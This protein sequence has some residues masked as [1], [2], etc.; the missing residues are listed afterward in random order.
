M[1]KPI[2]KSQLD[3]FEEIVD[4]VFSKLGIDVEFT[5]HFLDRINDDRNGEQITI[6][7]LGE[8]F[9]KE[10]RRWGRRISNMP[11]DSE[12]VMKDLSSE[13]NLPFVLKR[14]GQ[15]K[16]LVAKTIMRKKEFRTTNPELPVESNQKS[17]PLLGPSTAQ[18]RAASAEESDREYI[19]QM[20]LKS[21]WKA[22]FP[23][24]KWPGY[25]R[26]SADLNEEKHG[27]KRGAQVRGHDATTKKSRPT[28]GNETPH[29]MR[30]KLVGESK[31]AG[32]KSPVVD[33]ANG[34]PI[35]DFGKN[36][37][38]PEK[39]FAVR[40]PAIDVWQT[41]APTLADARERANNL[42]PAHQPVARTQ[43]QIDHEN[44]RDEQRARLA[45]GEVRRA[46]RSRRGIGEA[47]EPLD[48]SIK[49]SQDM[50]SQILKNMRQRGR[51]QTNALQAIQSS[52][53]N[54]LTKHGSTVDVALRTAQ[55]IAKRREDI[56]GDF[57]HAFEQS[58]RNKIERSALYKKDYFGEQAHNKN[59]YYVQPDGSWKR[60]GDGR[61]KGRT[62]KEIPAGA[63]IVETYSQDDISFVKKFIKEKRQDGWTVYASR[64]SHRTEHDFRI[65]FERD[66]QEFEVIGSGNYW[67][68][69][70]G[71]THSGQ[72]E[73]FD[74]LDTAFQTGTYQNESIDQAPLDVDTSSAAEI[75]QKHG[76]DLEMIVDQL[77]RGIK[78]EMEHTTDPFAALEIALDHLEEM[79][80]YYSKLDDMERE[81]INAGAWECD[82][83]R[84]RW[85]KLRPGLDPREKIL[86]K[87]LE[88]LDKL[89][90]SKGTEKHSIGNYAFDIV[91]SFNL[92]GIATSR[93]LTAMYKE[94]KGLEK[95][96]V[97]EGWMERNLYYIDEIIATNENFQDGKIKGK[98]RPGRA[99]RAGVDASKSVSDLRKQAKNSSGETQKMAHWAANMKSGRRK[100]K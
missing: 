67:E 66:G 27:A 47:Q 39:R 8:L 12:A 48:G 56:P 95:E 42:R 58:L 92:N 100:K 28:T 57:A 64:T 81:Q 24:K 20:M 5:R 19:E 70:R 26:A 87:A 94:W 69:F 45:T 71:P 88:Y 40:D 29:P 86:A 97:Y 74:G 32:G 18:D 79:P 1:S 77:Q 55:R 91:R 76:V 84:E 82:Q 44:W 7:E 17:R 72:G 4:R 2:T 23:G 59:L 46:V 34:Y 37:P 54:Q 30:G 16:D 89:V 43:A 98:S 13:L 9:A 35:H 52:M 38:W 14:D 60:G 11:V 93:E 83:L 85:Q 61:S 21:K 6:K 90:Q 78:V 53:E 33:T 25:S 65:E 96:S 15:E 80:D 22:A 50:I 62:R 75:A 68:L 36:Y 31:L 51:I 10:Y 63:K 49:V 41:A 3:K 73:V 99:K